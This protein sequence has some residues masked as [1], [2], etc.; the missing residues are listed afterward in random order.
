M[1]GTGYQSMLVQY[2]NE[3]TRAAGVCH[4]A[5]PEQTVRG[6]PMNGVQWNRNE[7]DWN[8][9]TNERNKETDK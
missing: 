7:S 5:A 2:G 4:W 3:V 1:K 9:Q 8:T 6:F